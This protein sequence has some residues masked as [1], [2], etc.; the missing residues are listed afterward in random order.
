M[1]K[2]WECFS[3]ATYFDKWAIRDK[4]DKSFTSAIHVETYN[5]AQDI[6]DK[7][8]K[9]EELTEREAT[10]IVAIRK[11]LADNLH[12]ADGDNCTLITLK[13]VLKELGIKWE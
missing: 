5:E 6:T 11:T 7:F 1:D 9:L 8:N 4:R 12:L 2:N 10:L 3:D 13:L